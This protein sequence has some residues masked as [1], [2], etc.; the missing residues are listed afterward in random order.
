MPFGPLAT[1]SGGGAT[2]TVETRANILALTPTKSGIAY[3]TDTNEF[4]LW[5]DDNSEWR[6][7]S[8]ELQ[9]ELPAPDMGAMIPGG[10]G[11][12]DKAGYYT[13]A[14]TDKTLS[15]I[16][17]GGNAR[18]ENG[19]LRIDV[20]QDPDTLEVYL[21][22]AWQSII[23]DFTTEYDDLRH[24]P[25]DEQIHVQSGNSVSVGLNGL[26]IVQDYQVSMGANPPP[27]IVDGGTF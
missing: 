26:P 14:I 16:L 1:G 6:V 25:L 18:T 27:R 23:Y 2:L 8:L 5:D 20:T 24:T 7:A 22:G 12:T 17:L 15:N 10:L 19:G 4:L 21:R 11:L 3:A 13:D 9:I